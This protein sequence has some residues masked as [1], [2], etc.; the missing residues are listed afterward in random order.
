MLMTVL[1]GDL[2]VRQ[3]K[4]L[5]R[6]FKKLKDY[7]IRNRGLIGEY[8][9]L[10]LSMQ[11]TNSSI[12]AAELRKDLTEVEEQM[13]EMVESLN[14][15]VTYSELAEYMMEFGEPHIR[16]GYLVYN[17]QPFRSDLIFAEIYGTA[18]KSIFLIDNYIN[19][20]T[21]QLMIYSYKG[22]DITVFTDNCSKELTKALFEDFKK[23]YPDMN[24]K[25]CQSGGVFHDR[26]IVLDYGTK[27]EK[28]F[29]CGASSKDGG[30]R[31]SSVLEDRDKE[32]YRDMIDGII[33]NSELV[34]K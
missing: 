29:L 15:M 25:I 19:I 28:I 12:K 20:K 24:I 9:F 1:K 13:A 7:M 8:D 4:A 10:Q 11:V 17:G 23:E 30:R 22:V 31:I 34:L 27:G 5:I 3:S 2:A 21:L 33:N 6:I 32:K 18:K 16:N 14:E 26:Y